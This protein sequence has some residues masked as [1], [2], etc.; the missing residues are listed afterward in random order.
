MIKVLIAED[1]QGILDSISN[2][3]SWE[4]MGC[5]ISGLAQNGIH[6]LELCLSNPPDII[7]SD[8]V[9]PG[10]DGITFLRYIREKHPRTQFII[11]TG[12]RNFEYAKDAVNLGASLFLLKPINFTE[13]KNAILK[14]VDKILQE[15]KDLQDENQQEHILSSL[16]NGYI[17]SQHDFAPKIQLLLHSLQS[18]RICTFQFDD[19]Q[20]QDIFRIQ[21]LA[22]FCES[23]IQSQHFI[24]VKVNALHYALIT[25]GQ[26][27]DHPE[28]LRKTLKQLQ[29]RIYQFFH[30]TISIGISA[31]HSGYD[32]LHQAYLES[33][34]ALGKQFFSGNQSIHVFLTE[35]TE[36]DLSYTDYNAVFLYQKKIETLIS[37]FQGIYLHQQASSLFYEWIAASNGNVVLI[38]SSF[39]MLAVLC[40]RNIVGQDNKQTALFFEK[41]ANFQKVLRCDTLEMLKEI[42][43]NLIIDLNDYRSI[44]TSNKQELINKILD[45]IQDHYM[46]TISLSTVARTVFLS[47]S[48]LSTLITNETGKSFTDIV[49]EIRISKA[50]ELLKNPKRKIAD[51]AFSVGFNEPQYFSIIFKKCTNLTPRDYREFYLSSTPIH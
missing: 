29:N 46:E 40:I 36:Q 22:L 34:R 24:P 21:N 2:A 9:M 23:T 10:I 19:G 4:N 14:L 15:E 33:L 26:D 50:I 38:K 11:L 30:T 16:L 27:S 32:T 42:Y 49:N 3:F 12:H 18:Y 37:S 7:I 41:Y 47:P 17:Y 48:Y 45:Y 35:N 44:K 28:E 31:L 39:I 13:L 6:A 25:T 51:I 8:I 5:E 43:L 20:E 1:E